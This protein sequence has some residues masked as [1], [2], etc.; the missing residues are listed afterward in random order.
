MA[1][2]ALSRFGDAEALPFIREQVG[3]ADGETAR[4]AAWILARVGDASDIPAL[5]AGRDRYD[6]P[7]T[8]AYFQHALAALG[9]AEGKA[10]LV[11]NLGHEDPAVRVY[12][13]EFAPDG[14]VVAARE[15]LIARL[16]DEVPDIRIRAAHALLA[17]SMPKK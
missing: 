7:L 5:R 14:R 8:K 1:A 9:D 10:A 2:A 16:D 17:L 15:T 13:A 6:E 4:T 12:A 11:R 3:V